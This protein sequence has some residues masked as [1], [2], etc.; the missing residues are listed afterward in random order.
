M[1][2]RTFQHI[3]LTYGP[4]TSSKLSLSPL[5]QLR[6]L[7]QKVGVD[8]SNPDLRSRT[9][10]LELTRAVSCPPRVRK[11]SPKKLACKYNLLVNSHCL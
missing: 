8:L 7:G 5:L 10:F 2:M 9:H 6:V 3:P 1:S 11:S 4:Q